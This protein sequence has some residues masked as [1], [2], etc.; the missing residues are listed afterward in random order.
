MPQPSRLREG[1]TASIESSKLAAALQHRGVASGDVVAILATNSP[2][3]V[4]AQA[5]VSKLGA[6][7]ALI[8][9]ALQSKLALY[10]S[11]AH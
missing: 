1:L 11:P 3:M 7:P 2:E 4:F 6:V 5:A 9:T 8:N 10:Q